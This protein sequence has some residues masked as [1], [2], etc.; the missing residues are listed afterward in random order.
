MVV[1]NRLV[2]QSDEMGALPTLYAAT[3]PG[4]DGG[5]YVGP[6]GFARQRGYPERTTPSKAARD[7]QVA[8]RLWEVSEEMGGVRFDLGAAA[9]A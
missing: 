9:G 7:E 4:L 5:T 1:S 8:R 2:A 3:E 6:D